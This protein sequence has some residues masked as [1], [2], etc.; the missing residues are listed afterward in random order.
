MATERRWQK[1]LLGAL[2]T[3]L[4]V[5][6]YRIWPTAAP[7]AT[8]APASNTQAS[9][10][11]RTQQQQQ[12]QPPPPRAA[13]SSSVLT[14]DVH[15]GALNDERPKPGATDRNLFRFKPKAAPPP[16][17]PTPVR[18]EPTAPIA[19]VASGPLAPPPPPIALKF[20]G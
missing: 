3:A 8:P 11:V 9:N 15:L 6:L 12:Q 20:L 14:P 13:A 4:L 16:P 17:T 1:L 5:I 2:A 18:P 19:P 7:S 10:A